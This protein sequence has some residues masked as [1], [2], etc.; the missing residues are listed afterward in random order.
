MFPA[1]P[2]MITMLAGAV[3][4]EGCS[5]MV[6]Y[7]FAPNV[8]LAIDHHESTVLLNLGAMGLVFYVL[9]HILVTD[10]VKG[11]YQFMSG[12]ET[13]DDRIKAV[14]AKKLPESWGKPLYTA[15]VK[16]SQESSTSVEDHLVMKVSENLYSLSCNGN[17]GTLLML[18]PDI[19]FV[20]NH[21]AKLLHG[22]KTHVYKRDGKAGYSGEIELDY[23]SGIADH[24]GD[25]WIGPVFVGSRVRNIVPYF[26]T[27]KPSGAYTGK[28][29]R[30]V[31][32][33][34]VST[35]TSGDYGETCI[36]SYEKYWAYRYENQGKTY[37]GDCVVQLYALKGKILSLVEFTP[38]TTRP[39]LRW[40]CLSQFLLLG[41]R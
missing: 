28:L 39:R 4:T 24:V 5:R 18:C 7:V 9:R 30:P 36:Q 27:N 34:V 33:V 16:L 14:R 40:Q 20:P 32:G 29:L 17:R 6:R 37:D 26:P 1:N 2:L 25:T 19:G 41:M 13:P 8:N 3:I 22:K 10:S 23:D 35:G 31:N 11:M 12:F 21:V 15:E 38:D